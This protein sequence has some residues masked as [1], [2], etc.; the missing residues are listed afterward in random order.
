MIKRIIS[1]MA[2]LAILSTA[3]CIS[4]F[5]AIDYTP[6]RK[7]NGYS[8]YGYTS[9]GSNVAISG[10]YCE[11]INYGKRVLMLTNYYDSTGASKHK[12][13]PTIDYITNGFDTVTADI[14]GGALNGEIYMSTGYH[15]VRASSYMYWSSNESDE[16]TFVK[17]N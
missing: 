17:L 12:W 8:L 6:T 16:N 14:N 3:C 9:I 15:W 7:M 5:A 11:N 2:V 4:A 1:L 13:S 10:T